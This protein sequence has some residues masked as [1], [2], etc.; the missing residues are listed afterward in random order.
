MADER[1]AEGTFEGRYVLLQKAGEGT[2]GA[3]FRARDRTLDREV[4]LKV[5]KVRSGDLFEPVLARFRREVEIMVRYPHPAMVPVLDARLEPPRPYL[6][7]TWM[8]G[9]DLRRWIERG[10]TSPS[11][12][13][14]VGARL[15]D[16]LGHL[17]GHEV[18]HRDVKPANVLCDA[19]GEVYLGDL[20]LGRVEAGDGLTETGQVVG[21]PNYMAPETMIEG[22]SVPASDLFALAVLLLELHQGKG[23]G[24]ATRVPEA[25]EERLARVD[26][27]PLR[28]LL[29]RCLRSRPEHRPTSC[30]EVAEQL[31]ALALAEDQL[32]ETSSRFG[33]SE[34]APLS[35]PEST[36]RTQEFARPV[37]VSLVV[38]T[39]AAFFLSWT[40]NRRPQQAPPIA[41]P[42]LRSPLPDGTEEVLLGELESALGER[43]RPAGGQDLA[44]RLSIEGVVAL[45]RLPVHRRVVE[46]LAAHDDV[47]ALPPSTLEVLRR[48]DER[49]IEVGFPPAHRPFLES[50]PWVPLP[51]RREPE[52]GGRGLLAGFAPEGSC[53]KWRWR[54]AALG[55]AALA[56]QELEGIEARIQRKDLVVDHW[57]R[58]ATRP[59]S[60]LDLLILTHRGSDAGRAHLRQ[61]MQAGREHTRDFLLAMARSLDRGEFDPGELLIETGGPARA[62]KI[63]LRLLPFLHLTFLS[64]SPQRI[65]VDASPSEGGLIF[66]GI[67]TNELY[68]RLDNS[69][70]LVPSTHPEPGIGYLTAALAACQRSGYHPHALEVWYTLGKRLQKQE[71]PGE[72]LRLLDL[73]EAGL[74][75]LDPSQDFLAGSLAR[76]R[77]WAEE[78]QR[79]TGAG[80]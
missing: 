19:R 16:A 26:P 40:P 51:S 47:S 9:G 13:A 67:V 2:F 23:V 4:A 76:Y 72:L 15:A 33:A 18:L 53:E 29:R 58:L 25:L 79:S 62:T 50:R 65:F 75:K 61:V 78:E 21:T 22:R 49:L 80:R 68:Q 8:P 12:V 64:A 73:H 55:H 38:A 63:A 1:T 54:C 32:A 42:L 56:L 37:L 28:Q 3:V 34:V 71:R 57:L 44:D 24:L 46:W 35:P 69:P 39:L 5:L 10:P 36:K 45:D 7:S 43:P 17:H 66:R 74:R 30:K 31:S 11:Q 60:P 59:A 20:G 52:D 6:A 14:Q 70:V 41:L 48:F 77:A 27:P